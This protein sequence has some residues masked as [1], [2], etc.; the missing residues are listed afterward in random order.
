MRNK[1]LSHIKCGERTERSTSPILTMGY[2]QVKGCA[3]NTL[4]WKRDLVARKLV[5]PSD[6]KTGLKWKK[7]NSLW[8]VVTISLSLHRLRIWITSFAQSMEIQFN[9][10]NWN[11]S[12]S[13]VFQKA[14]KKITQILSGEMYLSLCLSEL[15]QIKTVRY[16]LF[17]TFLQEK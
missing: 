2:S 10:L 12:G 8:K 3:K 4:P 5:S 9:K 16:E 17:V 1:T 13:E 7:K 15:V 6:K 14:W 11:A